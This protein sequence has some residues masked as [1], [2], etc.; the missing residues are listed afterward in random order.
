GMVNVYYRTY[1]TKDDVIGVACVSPGLQRAFMDVLGLADEAPR[2]ASRPEQEGYYAELAR[3]CEKVLASRTAAA[4]K[5]IFDQRGVPG[6]AVRFSVELFDD[7]QARAN[8][9][10]HDLPHPALGP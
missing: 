4:W 6:A 9:F 7:E 10:F 8:G 2:G 3:R 5:P 1:A